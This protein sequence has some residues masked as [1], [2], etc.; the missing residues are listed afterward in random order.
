MIPSTEGSMPVRLIKGHKLKLLA[1]LSVVVL[2]IFLFSRLGSDDDYL[3]KTAALGNTKGIDYSK[4]WPIVDEIVQKMTLQQKIGQMTLVSIVS[5]IDENTGGINFDLLREYQVGGVYV[6]G[7][8]I[9]DGRGGLIERGESC[10]YSAEAILTATLDEW[11]EYARKSSIPTIVD[12][13]RGE[14]VEIPPLIGI[15]APNGNQ[16]VLGSVLFPHNIGLSATHDPELFCAAGYFTAVDV[17]DAG[18]NWSFSPAISV[19]HNPKWGR[20][21]ETMGNNPTMIEKYARSYVAGMQAASAKGGFISGALAT[22]KHYVGDGAVFDG[23][24]EGNVIVEKGAEENFF[25]INAA[26]FKGAIAAGVG[27]IM[28]AY[29]AVNDIW[30]SINSEYNK[31]LFDGSLTGVHTGFLVSDMQAI[32]KIATQGLPTVA[33]KLP[34]DEALSKGVMAGIDMKMTFTLYTSYKNISEF[35]NILR[36]NI[37]NGAISRERVDDAVRRILAVKY[38]MGLIRKTGGRWVSNAR[39]AMPPF[40]KVYPVDGAGSVLEAAQATAL[41]AAEKSLVLLKND[42]VIPVDIRRLKYIVLVGEEIIPTLISKKERRDEVYQ[43]FDNIGA[44]S[45]GWTVT[46]QGFMGNTFWEGE[47]KRRARAST[48][49]D[50]IRN[51]AEREHAAVNVLYPEYTD[52][53]DIASVKLERAEFIDR[54]NNIADMNRENTLII[55]AIGEVPYAEFM[56]DVDNPYCRDTTTDFENGCLYNLHFN[57]Y[58]PDTQPRTLEKDFDEFDRSV[59]DVVKSRISDPHLITVLFSGRPLIINNVLKESSA[60]I[61]AFLPGPTGG[62]AVA[63]AIFGKYFFCGGK[64]DGVCKEGDPNTLPVDWIRD[65]DSLS[66]IPVYRHGQEGVPRAANPLFPAGWG[67]ATAEKPFD[68]R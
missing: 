58:M 32:N 23:I 50:G 44:Q 33:K 63:N 38:A 4:F 13:E 59:I 46:W 25:D 67:L 55:A 39:P 24:D 6:G 5:L 22:A 52:K 45:G 26:G 16:H 41:K 68:R 54:L 47:N 61:A 53:T 29:N 42:G 10:G 31:K 40:E 21:Y 57:W 43:Y 34:Y 36:R 8:D 62:E 20:F 65:M 11:R 18:F 12:L 60:F 30:M 49:I 3:C 48:V 2:A 27:S 15:D 9:P 28:V 14:K 37:E 35:Q 64:E 7:N 66:G 19:A 56:G 1:V 17:L 51:L